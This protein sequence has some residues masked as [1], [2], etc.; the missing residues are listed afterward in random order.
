MAWLD[1]P[2]VLMSGHHGRIA[3][4][5]RDESVRLTCERRPDLTDSDFGVPH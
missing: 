3:K 4:W 2:E 5:R 1:V